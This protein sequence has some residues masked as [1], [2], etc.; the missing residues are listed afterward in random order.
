MITNWVA[1]Q[2]IPSRA[3]GEK[4]DAL[5]ELTYIQSKP[6]AETATCKMRFCISEPQKQT[7][8]IPAG[9]RVT[10][11]SNTLVWE[12][13]EDH[14]VPAGESFTEA[15]I[16]RCQTIGTAGNGYAVGQINSQVDVYEYYSEC[17]NIAVPDGGSDVPT[18]D[19]FYELMRASMDAYSTAGAR[20]SYLLGQACQHQNRG[21]GGSFSYSYRGQALCA[22]GRWNA[23]F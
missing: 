14:Y 16:V 18:D 3:D 2:N 19:E 8:L 21:C 11:T 10:D 4:L 13:M 5:A 15:I 7:I 6:E 9:T 1:N 22:Y 17:S 12:T 20:G 23:G